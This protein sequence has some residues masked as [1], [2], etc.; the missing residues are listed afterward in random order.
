[1]RPLAIRAGGRILLGCV[2]HRC[3]L[4][5]PGGSKWFMR[6]RVMSCP[7]TWPHGSLGTTGRWGARCF[8]LDRGTLLDNF[9]SPDSNVADGSV[10]WLALPIPVA[11]A[12]IDGLYA[13]RGKLVAIQNGVEP[14]RLMVLDLAGAAAPLAGDAARDLQ[15][16][17]SGLSRELLVFAEDAAHRGGIP[18]QPAMHPERI[19]IHR[20]AVDRRKIEFLGEVDD[21]TERVMVVRHGI[22]VVMRDRANGPLLEPPA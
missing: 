12:G 2:P 8:D 7:S 1:M 13:W 17:I 19:E 11:T 21:L 15:R 3:G 20:D 22:A 16:A 10:A 5:R 18:G 4:N 9:E 6:G 14:H